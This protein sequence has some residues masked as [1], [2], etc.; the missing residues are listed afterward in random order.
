METRRHGSHL[1]PQT[2]QD[3]VEIFYERVLGW[4]LHIADLMA[5]GGPL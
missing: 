4:Q 3:K 1:A 5:N 2:V